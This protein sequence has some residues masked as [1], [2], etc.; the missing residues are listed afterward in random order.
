MHSAVSTLAG[1]PAPGDPAAGLWA[2]VDTPQA[3]YAMVCQGNVSDAATVERVCAA[4]TASGFQAGFGD[5]REYTQ[6]PS[7][8][9]LGVSVRYLKGPWT[10]WR[11][12]DE[13]SPRW[14]RVVRCPRSLRT[15]YAKRDVE[16]PAFRADHER[17]AHETDLIVVLE[18]ADEAAIDRAA[19][20]LDALL[21]GVRRHRGGL[22]PEGRDPF[23]FRDGVSNLQDLRRLDPH[24][25][26]RHVL[27]QEPDLDVPGS[28]LV[29]R[30]YRVFPDRLA[31]TTLTVR[32]DRG[33]P[34]RV[35]AVEQVIGRCR[36][37]GAV[38][39]GA[40]GVHLRAEADERQ[41]AAAFAQSH[42]RKANPRGS[43]RTNFGHDVVVPEV[44]ILRRGYPYR[45]AGA[46]GPE[47]GLLFLAFQAD[48]QDGGFEFIHNEWLLSD[49]NGA[50]DPLLAPESGLVEPLTGCYYFIP[51]EQR[52][53]AEILRSLTGERAEHGGRTP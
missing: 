44:R 41:G 28:Y 10:A 21:D 48:V 45:V 46:D 24:R 29:F 53:L 8:F 1:S 9:L 42:L 13:Y 50:P 35:V 39:D 22:R 32:D 12:D 19:G 30:R 5:P 40:T 20:R 51:R 18:S 6:V 38:L 16:F 47:E 33:D 36:P 4:L 23:G 34:T 7:T 27:H 17:T 15:M 49:F 2:G 52:R 31:G 26:A 43:G 25:Y 11:D 3:P 14:G 37:C